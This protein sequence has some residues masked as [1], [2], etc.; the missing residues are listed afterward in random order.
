MPCQH[1]TAVKLE[2]PSGKGCEESKK[3]RGS[4]WVHL[5][6]CLECGRVGCCDG[7]SPGKHPSAHFHHTKHPVMASL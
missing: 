6:V 4:D 1:I 7:F 3:A 5:R 2:H